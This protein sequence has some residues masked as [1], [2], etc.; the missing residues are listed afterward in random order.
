MAEKF[1]PLRCNARMIQD[2]FEIS[3]HVL[4][5]HLAAGL[6]H[7]PGKRGASHVFSA[8][9]VH[10]WLMERLATAEEGDDELDATFELAALRRTQRELLEIKKQ[11]ATGELL[12]SDDVVRAWAA[13][14]V[15]FRNR[16][17]QIPPR[18]RARLPDMPAA[19]YD[20]LVHLIR[21]AL[22]ELSRSDPLTGEDVA[23]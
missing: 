9:A 22:T 8:P 19:A 23:G 17:L 1:D 5:N 3:P 14:L 12:P 15:L 7:E 11:E 20:E 13:V 2:I 18:L 4:R 10:R 21:E 6:P 16:C